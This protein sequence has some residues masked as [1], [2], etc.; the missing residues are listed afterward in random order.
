[1]TDEVLERRAVGAAVVVRLA[2]ERH[3]DFAREGLGHEPGDGAAID[4]EADQRAPDGDAGDEGAGAV[5][6]VDDPAE[7]AGAGLVVPLLADDRMIGEALAEECA[8]GE[9][10]LAIGLGNG[11]E[12]AGLLVVHS[13]GLAEAGQGLGG[14]DLG[15]IQQ[16]LP[17]QVGAEATQG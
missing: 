5:D 9:F 4:R 17:D 8:D 14:G 10:G 16:G 12:T 2:G 3:E 15:R 1:M 13:D 11:I 6:W 7:A